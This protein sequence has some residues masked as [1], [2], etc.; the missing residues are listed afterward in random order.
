[1]IKIVFLKMKRKEIVER[2]NMKAK[3]FVFS[4]NHVSKIFRE[5]F[6]DLYSEIIKIKILV[7]LFNQGNVVVILACIFLKTCILI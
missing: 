4:A 6:R 3:A 7:L 5:I 1:M 2:E